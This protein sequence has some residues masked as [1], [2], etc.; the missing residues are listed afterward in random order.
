MCGFSEDPSYVG[1]YSYHGNKEFYK[2]RTYYGKG[3][4]KTPWKELRGPSRFLH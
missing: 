3:I 1:Q 4:K 2:K